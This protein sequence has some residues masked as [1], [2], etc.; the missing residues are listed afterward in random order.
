MR[1]RTS[2][3]LLIAAAWLLAGTASI[4]AAQIIDVEFHFTPFTGDP[5]EDRVRTVA[6]TARVYLNNVPIVEHP[7]REQTVPVLFAAREI[8]PSLWVRTATLGPLLRQGRNTL[9]VEFTPEDPKLAYR[10]QLRWAAVGDEVRRIERPGGG[11]A[12]NRRDEGMDE[13]RGSGPL[14]FERNFNAPFGVPRPWHSYPP[15]G[16]LS[17]DDR[18]Q[19]L[20]IVQS[21][22][23][24]FKPDF[25]ALY[26]LLAD[27]DGI[28]AAK[29]RKAAC[30][31]KGYA[32]GI[33]LVAVPPGEIDLRTTGGPEV[34]VAARKGEL[35][36]PA[37]FKPFERIRGEEL[38]M[39]IGLS[40]QA[41]YPPRL[42]VVKPPSGRWEV[43]R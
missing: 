43:V 41:A 38:Q 16:E 22:V 3:V 4:A 21:R 19:I 8:A 34:V 25:S 37:D 11:S 35:F 7:V 31:D 15:V 42:I 28:D 40:L 13:Q 17:E 5:K 12:T 14:R 36:R 6:G 1:N 29:V 10:A 24:A 33:R 30:L 39:C 20:R 26:R 32:A 23:D 2:R 27:T 18:Q 9:R